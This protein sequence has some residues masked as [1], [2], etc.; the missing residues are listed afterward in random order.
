MLTLTENCDNE[1][2]CKETLS[3]FKI[4]LSSLFVKS[5]TYLSIYL[6]IFWGLPFMRSS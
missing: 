1:I 3:E 6:F 2:S 5:L 4:Y